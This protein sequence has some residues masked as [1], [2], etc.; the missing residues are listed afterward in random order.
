MQSEIL[1]N[2]PDRAGTLR[3]R[4]RHTD[5]TGKI[6]IRTYNC[7]DDSDVDALLA[8]N[9][10][11]L[12]EQLIESEFQQYMSDIESGNNPFRD[13]ENNP[14]EPV[15]TDRTV[16]LSKV[17]QAVCTSDEPTLFMKGSAYMSNLS[18]AELSI[19]LDINQTK[20]DEIRAKVVSISDVATFLNDYEAPL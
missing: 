18:D 9:A 3:I 11:K 8:Q 7:P 19:L 6:H 5:K 10:I 15:F 12:G 1:I 2:R 20:V 16:M 17:L 4:E 13:S 14:I